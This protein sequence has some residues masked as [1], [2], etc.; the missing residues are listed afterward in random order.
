[1]MININEE[2]SFE[3][4]HFAWIREFAL[5]VIISLVIEGANKAGAI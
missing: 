4:R 1:M 3:E 2:Y 5:S